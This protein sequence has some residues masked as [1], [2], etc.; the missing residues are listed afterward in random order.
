[1]LGLSLSAF[2]LLHVA[3]SLVGLGAGLAVVPGL[4]RGDRPGGLTALFLATT[5]LTSV[6]G[7]LFPFSGL[8]PSH[9]VGGLSLVVLAGAVVAL[10]GFHLAGAWRWIYV[11]GAL[12][13]LYFNA[14]VAIAQAFQ[15]IAPLQALAPTQSEGPFVG[16]QIALLVGFLV[17]GTLGIRR[18]RPAVA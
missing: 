7:F 14:F 3:V 18:F 4:L 17:L 8:L 2:T 11:V 12:A 10:Y 9:V 5:V 16:A 6:T 13:G 1:M 15:K